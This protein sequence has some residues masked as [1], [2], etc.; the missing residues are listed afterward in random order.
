M[1]ELAF[2]AY[3]EE[4]NGVNMLMECCIS[5]ETCDLRRGNDSSA[6]NGRE[7]APDPIVEVLVTATERPIEVQGGKAM[8]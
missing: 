6:E 7:R 5:A 4:V 2:R 8:R 3:C 1:S